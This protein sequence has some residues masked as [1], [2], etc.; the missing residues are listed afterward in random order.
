MRGL[1]SKTLER[2][3]GCPD[4]GDG[5]PFHCEVTP[6]THRRKVCVRDLEVIDSELRLLLAIRRMVREA[7]GRTPNTARI[8]ALLDERAA[9]LDR[10]LS[11]PA[12]NSL[13]SRR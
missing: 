13:G 8:D 10:A 2:C 12:A 3:D 9:A 4:W 11:Q 5:D 6:A 7:E 1:F